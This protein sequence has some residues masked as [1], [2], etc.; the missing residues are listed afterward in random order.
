[1]RVLVYCVKFL[2]V[3]VLYAVIAGYACIQLF[4]LLMPN[5]EKVNEGYAE[6][7]SVYLPEKVYTPKEWTKYRPEVDCDIEEYK[8]F[9]EKNP[10]QNFVVVARVKNK[11]GNDTNDYTINYY[12]AP[13]AMSLPVFH[14]S[15]AITAPS[16]KAEWGE[17]KAS[18]DKIDPKTKSI[19][20]K[21]NYELGG[22]ILGIGC[23]FLIFLFVLWC[24]GF[25]NVCKWMDEI[26]DF[27][28]KQ[29]A[30]IFIRR[31]RIC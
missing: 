12:A 28:D 9:L 15:V 21:M 18:F 13:E 11:S 5:P 4:N 3:L 31:K 1:M 8:A 22:L 7:V 26:L 16:K 10:S 2:V 6:N 27:V 29:F 17:Y 25:W 19:S 30:K 23:P 14:S 24:C 20:F